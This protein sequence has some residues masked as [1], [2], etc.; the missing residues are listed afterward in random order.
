MIRFVGLFA[1]ALVALSL[2]TAA[3]SSCSATNENNDQRCSVDCSA[4]QSASCSDA[5]GSNTPSCS[6]SGIPAAAKVKNGRFKLLDNAMI[7]FADAD[8][9]P[10][11]VQNT[12]LLSVINSKL[13]SLKDYHLADSCHTEID[14]ACALQI[15]TAFGTFIGGPGA[16]AFNES[17][18]RQNIQIRCKRD[19]CQPVNGKLTIQVPLIV[20]GGPTVKIGQPN[21]KDIPSDVNMHHQTYTNCSDAQQSDSFQHS[22]TRTVGQQITKTKALTTGSSQVVQISGSVDIKA[23]KL[24]GTDTLSVS[25]QTQITDA[26]QES[27]TDQKIDSITLPLVVPAMSL[28]EIRHSFIQYSVPIP[29]TGT[30]TVDGQVRSNLS[31]L[32]HFLPSFPIHPQGL[33]NLAES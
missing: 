21:W 15:Q 14:Q 32:A 26:N 2:S 25:T 29:F 8:V 17:V 28:M 20:S 3:Q 27:H 30:I 33:S 12:D 18:L 31:G 7:T 23:L 9:A 11:P 5:S 10:S 6:C 19:I 1:I 24:G 13:G 16:T 4:G 22:I